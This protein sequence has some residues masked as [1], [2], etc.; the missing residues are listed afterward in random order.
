MAPGVELRAGVGGGDEDG[1]DLVADEVV[2]VSE[3]RGDGVG[4]AGVALCG[5]VMLESDGDEKM[6]GDLR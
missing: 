5:R 4:V 1:E 3:A 2:A 6:G